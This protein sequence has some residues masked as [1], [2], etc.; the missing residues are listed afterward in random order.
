MLSIRPER[1]MAT[2]DPP[3]AEEMGF[4][5]RLED[6]V[7][8][9]GITELHLRSALSSQPIVANLQGDTSLHLQEGSEMW[10]RWRPR[11]VLAFAVSSSDR[12]GS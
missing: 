10:L 2:G 8:L 6:A 11:D 1:I 12:R 9:G 7:F 3:A 4:S 5:A